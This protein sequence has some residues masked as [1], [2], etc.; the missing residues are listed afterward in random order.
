M[1]NDVKKYCD[2]MKHRTYIA[3]KANVLIQ[4]TRYH[5]T[6][7]EQ[8]IIIFAISKIKPTDKDFELYQFDLKELCEVC[9][10]E[11]N[12]KNYQNFKE[13]IQRLADK[14]FWLNLENKEILCRWVSKV[15]IV[16]QTTTVYFRFD[17]TLKP[18]LLQ[19]KNNFT[20][21][22]VRYAL[23]LESNYSI[24][25][26]ELLKSYAFT[27][28]YIITIAE[29]MEK[30]EVSY[31]RMNN[32]RQRVLDVAIDEINEK[33]DLI[34]SYEFIRQNRRIHS[35]K[36]LIDKKTHIREYVEEVLEQR[37]NK[38]NNN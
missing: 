20:S 18:Y 28:E 16:P 25:F 34:V 19:L 35:I 37:K 3:V 30:L 22:E 38:L 26:Y 15:I 8:K 12:G 23:D 29:L 31:N 33:T 14:S 2:I 13:T 21:F 7:Q 11:Y 24:R 17:D 6:A 27:G 4:K 1:E 32:F 9:G 36:F 5:L 10:I